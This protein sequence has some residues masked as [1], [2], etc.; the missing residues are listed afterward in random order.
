M[1]SSLLSR[2]VSTQLLYQTIAKAVL[3][4][5]NNSSF[6]SRRSSSTE[7]FSVAVVDQLVGKCLLLID[8]ASPLPSSPDCSIVDCRDYSCSLELLLL[9]NSVSAVAHPELVD[10]L[11]VY[12]RESTHST[13]VKLSL[14]HIHDFSESQLISILQTA[15]DIRQR[16]EKQQNQKQPSPF[17]KIDQMIDLIVTSPRNQRFLI[18]PLQQLQ[19]QQLESLLSYLSLWL[20]VHSSYGVD[21]IQLLLRS[22]VSSSS[23]S[24]SPHQLLLSIEDQRNLRFPSLSQLLDWISAVC[25][26]QLAV[27]SFIN[28]SYHSSIERLETIFLQCRFYEEPLQVIAVNIYN[29]LRELQKRQSTGQSTTTATMTTS[30]LP[31]YRVESIQ[32]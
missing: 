20:L 3:P 9:S 23:S 31:L 32:L 11:R 30:M 2:G 10:I 26:S 21:E 18:L 7:R 24:S 5:L 22:D 25:D 4:H 12:L 1:A 19:P 16:Q 15:L 14:L 13:L 17:C 27:I 28:P 8:A 29:F 6:K